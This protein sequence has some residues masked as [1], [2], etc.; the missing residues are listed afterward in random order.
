MVSATGLIIYL[1]KEN[2]HL[3]AVEVKYRMIKQVYPEIG[4]WVDTTYLNNPGIAEKMTAKFE[5]EEAAHK[6]ND[7]L[8]KDS[9]PKEIARRR[10]K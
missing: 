7:N 6:A 3:E 2:T 8:E 1:W 10:K 9:N 4:L 5:S